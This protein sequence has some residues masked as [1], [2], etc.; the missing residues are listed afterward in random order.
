MWGI[1]ATFFT[2]IKL[3]KFEQLQLC[4]SD[5]S[6]HGAVKKGCPG[7][8]LIF[9][10]NSTFR[11]IDL[12]RKNHTISTQLNTTV[13]IFLLGMAFTPGWYLWYLSFH[14][15]HLS[16]AAYNWV[17]KVFITGQKLQSSNLDHTTP[18]A[19]G[20]MAPTVGTTHP[21]QAPFPRCISGIA[22][23]WEW[24]IGNFA[25]ERSWF[26]ASFSTGTPLIHAFT[27]TPFYKKYSKEYIKKALKNF[28]NQIQERSSQH[29]ST[30][31]SFP[32]WR[33]IW[34]H[35]RMHFKKTKVICFTYVLFIAENNVRKTSIYNPS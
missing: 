8:I 22:A 12:T 23:T 26:V 35:G 20:M 6:G 18:T 11:L 34:N 30:A 19:E 3:W 33:S 27:G 13:L 25:K 21:T 24:T 32:V 2:A 9:K 1:W 16:R 14:L 7:V 10:L 28:T 31:L 17:N 4:S 29:E 5:C 15:Q